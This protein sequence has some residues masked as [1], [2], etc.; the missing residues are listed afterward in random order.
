MTVAREGTRKTGSQLRE[1]LFL[2]VGQ[3]LNLLF[4]EQLPLAAYELK[5][6]FGWTA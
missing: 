4:S 6:L 2:G 5:L 1:K 3:R